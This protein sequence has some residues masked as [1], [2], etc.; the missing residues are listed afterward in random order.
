MTLALLF[1]LYH[2][3][4]T[5]REVV[6]VPVRIRGKNQVPDR[7]R[8]QVDKHPDYIHEAS[9]GD[10]DQDTWQTQDQSKQDQWHCGKFFLLSIILALILEGRQ[11]GLH[12]NEYGEGNG[13]RQHHRTDQIHEYDESH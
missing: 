10:D 11:N 8:N 2:T 5:P 3:C 1:T 7:Q 9:T 12:N 4:G 6:H 13:S